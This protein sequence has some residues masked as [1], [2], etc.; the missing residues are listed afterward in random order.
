M[1]TDALT[2]AT[3]DP[4]TRELHQQLHALGARMRAHFEGC[5]SALGLTFAQ[6]A[7]LQHL[8]PPIPMRDLATHLL[9][10]ASNIT[11]IVDRLEEA[12]LVARQPHPDDRRVKTVALTAEGRRRRDALRQRVLDDHPVLV[13]LDH[14]DRAALRDILAR[15][16]TA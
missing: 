5:A 4:V 13:A 6:A 2:D 16:L 9:C 11:G 12:G 10:D 8:D 3:T 1:I 15:V 14:H 7:A